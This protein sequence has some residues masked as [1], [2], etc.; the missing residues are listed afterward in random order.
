MSR[1]DRAARKK[2]QNP[3][4]RLKN[5]PNFNRRTELALMVI[6]LVG[7]ALIRI[8]LLGVPLERDEGEYAYMG[9]LLLKGIPPFREAFNMKFPGT[10]FG[11]AAVMSIFGETISG[12]HLG[13][14]VVNCASIV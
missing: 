4:D 3:G 7:V 9:Q 11:Y 13:L 12:I 14:L 5:P 10:Y 8:R 2:N 6:V 1:R